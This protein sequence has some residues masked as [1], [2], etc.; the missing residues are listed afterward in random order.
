MYIT[1]LKSDKGKAYWKAVQWAPSL[2]EI[3][4]KRQYRSNV[5]LSLPKGDETYI[6][7]K[8]VYA[9]ATQVPANA[10]VYRIGGD[11]A[12]AIRKAIL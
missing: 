7:D 12:R 9:A 1:V 6:E 4:R 8:T 5:S 3:R 10:E 11:T 2:I